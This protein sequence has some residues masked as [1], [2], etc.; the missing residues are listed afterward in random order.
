MARVKQNKGMIFDIIR[1]AIH[2][3]PGIRT[4]VFLKGCPLSCW[5]CQNPES[6]KLEPEKVGAIDRRK[7]SNLF[8]VEDGNII[9]REVT[10]AQV[11]A[12][13]DKDRIFYKYSGGGVTFS[14]GEPLMQP[15]F[16]L[17]LLK[18]SKKK[19]LHTALDTSGYASWAIVRRILKD[20]D[21]FLY[22]LKLMDERVHQKYTGEGNELILDNLRK[23]ARNKAHIIVRIPVITG[24]TDKRENIREI[25]EF[26]RS[27]KGIEQM[28]LL[29]YNYLCKDKYQRMKR[30]YAMQHIKPTSDQSLRKIK[31]HLETYGLRV[32]IEGGM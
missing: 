31:E 7:Y 28:H 27:V 29:P 4:T 19:G 22:D 11:M 10:V 3:G 26:V 24:I 15:D 1:Y 21:L 17:E 25:G 8:Y 9:G 23:L 12:E 5:W 6:Q 2:D 14:G 20:V 32:K 18:V 30:E 16:L 13:V